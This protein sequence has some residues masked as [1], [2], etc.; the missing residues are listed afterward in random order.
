MNIIFRILYWIVLVIIGL[1]LGK[2]L[3][4]VLF[5]LIMWSGIYPYLEKF[6]NWIIF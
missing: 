6:F 4:K 2:L 1:N 3:A 5:E